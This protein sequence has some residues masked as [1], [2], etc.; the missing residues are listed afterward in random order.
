MI[1]VL[2]CLVL[3][4]AGACEKREHGLTATMKIAEINEYGGI[5]AFFRDTD[6]DF[7][8]H[9]R[10]D[11]K[12]TGEN[13]E[14]LSKFDLRAGMVVEIQWPG[15]VALSSPEQISGV[16]SVRVIQQEDDFVG[17]YRSVFRKLWELEP[18][19]NRDITYACLDFSALT[20]LS[21]GELH[22]LRYLICCDM[23]GGLD[24]DFVDRAYIDRE[25]SYLEKMGEVSYLEKGLLL[26][27]EA[28]ER[29]E[30]R[31]VFTAMKWRGA[32]RIAALT[33]C[34]AVRGE[35]GAW[36]WEIGETDCS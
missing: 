6:R 25:V 23:G 30:D 33:D 16:T 5:F 2:A 27:V 3:F 19:L 26:T 29:T 14:K 20:D 8:V 36:S 4:L 11:V 22:T 13:G 12:I 21:E 28:T 1:L 34:V 32:E 17:L 10:E 7:F 18:E 9:L 31:I 35:H 24:L 15:S